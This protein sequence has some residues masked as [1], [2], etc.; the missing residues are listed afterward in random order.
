MTMG[1]RKSGKGLSGA[2]HHSG[3]KQEHGFLG[4]RIMA[5]P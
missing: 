4:A 5:M 2:I 1:L 3:R